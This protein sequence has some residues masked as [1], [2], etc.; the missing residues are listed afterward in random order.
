[1]AT[2]QP[3]SLLHK[4]ATLLILNL[5]SEEL[6]LFAY[7]I[8]S[9][10]EINVPYSKNSLKA[11]SI[12]LDSSS[13]LSRCPRPPSPQALPSNTFSHIKTS[14]PRS[15]SIAYPS[16]RMLWSSTLLPIASP[17][18]RVANRELNRTTKR[19]IEPYEGAMPTLHK[20]RKERGRRGRGNNGR[21]GMVGAESGE[22]NLRAD[23]ETLGKDQEFS[24]GIHQEIKRS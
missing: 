24:S 23:R 4:E 14:S 12:Y 22:R 17:R 15:K 1:M 3:Y 10:R 18:S 20:G 8:H 16:N 13:N 19:L 21:Y 2:N 5:A 6:C 9:F 11:F 7:Q